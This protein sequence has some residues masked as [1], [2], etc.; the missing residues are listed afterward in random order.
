M[1]LMN[2]ERLLRALLPG[3]ETTGS[4]IER[5]GNCLMDRIQYD[6]AT[7][8]VRTERFTL[9]DGSLRRMQFTARLFTFPELRDWLLQAGFS[10]VKGFGDQGKPLQVD[11]Q[12]MVVLAA[13]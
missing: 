1:D 7:G 10:S 8:C 12:R 2:R 4:V 3:Q 5:D 9:R 6:V 11:S 13:K